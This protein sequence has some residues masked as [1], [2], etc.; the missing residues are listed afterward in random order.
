M[1][2]AAASDGDWINAHFTPKSGLQKRQMGLQASRSVLVAPTSWPFQPRRWRRE[3]A[4]RRGPGSACPLTFHHHCGPAARDEQ[5]SGQERFA[6]A[7]AA[8]A[9][10]IRSAA[11]MA[12]ARKAAAARAIAENPKPETAA[13]FL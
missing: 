12:Y 2:I 7:I 4:A 5:D 11:A 8:V 1:T 10:L 3:L 9:A 13:A 6:A